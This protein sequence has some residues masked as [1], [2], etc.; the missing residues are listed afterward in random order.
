M[1]ENFFKNLKIEDWFQ[2]LVYLGGL[3]MIGTIFFPVIIF[4]NKIL[5]TFG[6]GL[7][8]LG[9]G[10]WARNR[11]GAVGTKAEWVKK[12]YIKKIIDNYYISALLTMITGF[13]LVFY[14]V[15][16]IIKTYFL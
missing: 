8:V 4:D 9:L 16:E 14:A 10:R 6:L 13:A 3:L 12:S 15:W 5:F 7:L 2:V 1:S 11:Y